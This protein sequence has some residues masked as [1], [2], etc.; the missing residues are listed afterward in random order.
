MGLPPSLGADQLTVAEPSPA[1]AATAPGAAGT[2][3]V[4][5]DVVTRSTSTAMSQVVDARVPTVAATAE[6][7]GTVWSSA[8]CSMSACGDVLARD[9]YPLPAVSVAWNPESAY[10]PSASSPSA[11][12]AAVVP[13]LTVPAAPVVPDACACW[14]RTPVPATVDSPEY[15]RTS[16]PRSAEEVAVA[17]TFGRVPPVATN[18]VHTLSSV[19][20]GAAKL[21]SLTKVSPASSVTD[22]VVADL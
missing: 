13:E 2:V 10:S 11:A 14:S 8:S 21:S 7:A 4:P 6:P 18:A 22:A 20:S 16:T 17:V 12:V 15:S 5:V 3:G 1:T 9:V 19:W